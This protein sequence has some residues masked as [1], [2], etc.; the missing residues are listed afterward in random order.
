MPLLQAYVV[1]ACGGIRIQTVTFPFV[2]AI[3]NSRLNLARGARKE[4][5]L[6]Q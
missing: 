5:R 3:R 1:R 2:A 6:V 4:F